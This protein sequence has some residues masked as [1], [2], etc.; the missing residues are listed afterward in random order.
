MKTPRRHGMFG[1]N[2]N[3]D[4]RHISSARRSHFTHKEIRFFLEAEWIPGLL[5]AD[6]RSKSLKN[7][8]RP[9]QEPNPEH[10]FL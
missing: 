4:I 9:C 5:N 6:R 2:P 3:F 10:S 7:L 8:Q 1:S